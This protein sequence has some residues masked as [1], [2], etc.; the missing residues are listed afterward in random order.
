ME[1]HIAG[2]NYR[3]NTLTHNVNELKRPPRLLVR[4]RNIPTELPPFV[5][6]FG[7]NFCG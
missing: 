1:E 7:A 3:F 2:M 4:K 5:A 6:K